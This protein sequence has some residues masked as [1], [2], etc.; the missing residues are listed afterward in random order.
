MLGGGTQAM[1]PRGVRAI[2][3]CGTPDIG[4]SVLVS[5]ANTI[6]TG[7]SSINPMPFGQRGFIAMR[8]APPSPLARLQVFHRW[9]AAEAV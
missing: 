1:R 5:G 9:K 4:Q 7:R 6:A 2:C 8:K 3:C